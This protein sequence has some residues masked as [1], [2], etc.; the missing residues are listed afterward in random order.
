VLKKRKVEDHGNFILGPVSPKEYKDTMAELNGSQ[1]NCVFE[2]FKVT[3]PWRVGFA[4]HRETAERKAVALAAASADT[5]ETAM[6]PHV[7]G[8]PSKKTTKRTAPA[9]AA[10]A[11]AK[12]KA[13]QK[14]GACPMSSPPVAKKTLFVDLDTGV[15]VTV[16]SVVPLHAAAHSG[17]SGG[18]IGGPLL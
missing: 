3:V 8:T 17:S 18:T 10:T 5:A 1:M 4:K 2:F 15:V 14:R 13:R 11:A 6:S 9:A 16:I 12:G 7:S